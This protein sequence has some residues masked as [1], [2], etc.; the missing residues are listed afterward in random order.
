[1]MSLCLSLSLVTDRESHICG[2]Q[3]GLLCWRRIDALLVSQTHGETHAG[4]LP[5]PE[6]LPGRY[7]HTANYIGRGKMVVYGGRTGDQ[8]LPE[9]LVLDL[10]EERWFVFSLLSSC[11]ACRQ[12]RSHSLIRHRVAPASSLGDDEPKGRAGHTASLLSTAISPTA[13]AA[14]LVARIVV[15]GGWD[16]SKDPSGQEV[17]AL[18]GNRCAPSRSLCSW[19]LNTHLWRPPSRRCGRAVDRV[20]AR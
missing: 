4:G 20:W 8:V 7:F 2:C 6:R 12:R 19:W 9:V 3:S 11:T 15:Y 5:A 1:M 10:A 13:R 14:Q 18:K 16:G 17:G